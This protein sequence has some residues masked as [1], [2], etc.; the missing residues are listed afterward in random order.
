MRRG[1]QDYQYFILLDQA[2]AQGRVDPKTYDDI[3]RAVD[4]LTEG[5]KGGIPRATMGQLESLRYRIGELLNQ[6]GS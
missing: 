1:F 3:R 2:R 6:A 4:G 5:L